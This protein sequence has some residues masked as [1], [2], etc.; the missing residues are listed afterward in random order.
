[1][2]RVVEE[3]REDLPGLV[4]IGGDEG[5]LPGSLQLYVDPLGEVRSGRVD[6][7]LR[8]AP[9]VECLRG[10]LEL[11]TLEAA[12]PEDVVDRVC[13]PVGLLRDDVQK[14]LPELL[15]EHDV[16]PSQRH[17]RAVHRGERRPELVRRR[18][19]ELRLQ[20]LDFPFLGQVAERV[21]GS[22]REAHARDR[23]PEL[24]TADLDR[25]SLRAGRRARDARD[26]HEP[27]DFLPDGHDFGDR[28][29]EHVPRGKT[30]DGL[31]CGVPVADDVSIVDEEDAVPDRR[32]DSGGVAALLGVPE[33]AR[34]VDGER[35]A[36]RQLAG[37]GE[38]LIRVAAARI[39]GEERQRADRLAAGDQR[40]DHPGDEVEISKENVVLV[41]TGHLTQ[42]GIEVVEEHRLAGAKDAP[43]RTELVRRVR[44][45]SAARAP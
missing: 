45:D 29:A 4:R 2:T 11:A 37:Q 14:P 8:E 9:R 35:R 1:M 10:E 41:V 36:P 24:T 40:Q 21:D 12:R 27:A 23:E 42:V 7:L 44:L 26:R 15:V 22:L 33:E 39:S 19:D 43:D 20:S 30:G 6:D 18:G 5:Q 38:V 13:E 32:K 28:A 3:V 31:C 16:S 17:C 34:V 25:Q